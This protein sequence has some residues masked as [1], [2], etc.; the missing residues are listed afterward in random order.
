MFL[1]FP[2]G[3]VKPGRQI[4]LFHSSLTLLERN[5]KPRRVEQCHKCWEFGHSAEH[6]TRPEVCCVCSSRD[7]VWEKHPMDTTDEQASIPRCLHCGGPHKAD[8]GK[9]PVRPAHQ[10]GVRRLAYPSLQN[11]KAIRNQQWKARKERVAQFAAEKNRRSDTQKD[12]NTIADSMTHEDT[13]T[14]EDPEPASTTAAA[15][16][17]YW[18][19]ETSKPSW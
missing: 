18:A 15:P 11:T 6:R 7:H 13:E 9:Y 2:A 17:R 16:D 1:S 12:P 19:P 10:N 14:T 5:R 8:Y 4:M 3:K